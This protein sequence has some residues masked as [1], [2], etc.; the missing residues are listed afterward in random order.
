VDEDQSAETAVERRATPGETR[1]ERRLERPPSDRYRDGEPALKTANR[2]SARSGLVLSTIA[3]LVGAAAIAVGGGLLTMTAGLLVVAAV[4]GWVV[5]VL[6]SIGVDRPAGRAS[7]TRRRW[8]A[9]GIALAGVAL[10]QLGLW[11]IARQEGGT[12]GLLDYL[13]EVFGVL[14]PLE[15]ALASGIAWWRTA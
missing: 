2:G 3:A 5:A 13:A 9:T 7:R 12:L 14:V 10:G 8:T 1:P 15:L 6:V 11:L 4:V